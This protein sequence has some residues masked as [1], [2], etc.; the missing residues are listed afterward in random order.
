MT[1]LCCNQIQDGFSH[2]D[3]EYWLLEFVNPQKK[4]IYW[5]S[6]Y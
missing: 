3:F 6:S 2:I 5:K 4:Y 1:K